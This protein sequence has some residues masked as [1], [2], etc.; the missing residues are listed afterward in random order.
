MLHFFHLENWGNNSS[1][2]FHTGTN[3]HEAVTMITMT[4]V[5]DAIRTGSATQTL[6]QFMCGLSFTLIA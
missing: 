2:K 1:F 4:Q 6:E 3:V 5:M